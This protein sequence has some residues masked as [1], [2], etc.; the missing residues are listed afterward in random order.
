MEVKNQGMILN[1]ELNIV[2]RYLR[3]MGIPKEDAE[4]IVQETAYK[5]LRYND[6]IQPSKTR[7]WLIR[8]AL[9]FHYDQCRKLSRIR[10]DL[11]DEILV[12]TQK[13]QPETMMLTKEEREELSFALAKIKPKFQELLLLKYQTGL[14]YQ[15]ISSIVC[16]NVSSVKTNLYRARNQLGKVLK[17]AANG[18]KK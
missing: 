11:N 15:E 16:M 12:A 9:N 10:L 6:S 2:Y 13:E 14:S 1:T 7:S 17:E 4:D 5:F 8:V 18:G 3:K